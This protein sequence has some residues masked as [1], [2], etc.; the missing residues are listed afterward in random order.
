MPGFHFTDVENRCR[1]ESD[2]Q[3]VPELRLEP[4]PAELDQDWSLAPN[5]SNKG[6]HVSLPTRHSP[7]KC[8]LSRAGSLV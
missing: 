3:L 6:P 1:E 2:S 7:L 8:I 5:I 4:R